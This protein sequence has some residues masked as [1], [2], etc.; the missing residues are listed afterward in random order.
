[1]AL[2]SG[3]GW[4]F[5]LRWFHFLAGITWI[6][7]LYFFNFVNVPGMKVLDPSA[8]PFVVTTILPRAL[9]WFRHAAWVT[10]LAG[11]VLMGTLYWSQGRFLGDDGAR[12]IHVGMLLGLIMLF[13]VWV[14]IWPNQKKVIAATAAKQAPEPSWARTALYASRTNVILSSPM[15]AFMAGAGHF[16]LGWAGI[17]V[18]GLV[19]AAIAALL[20]FYVHKAWLFA[21]K[22]AAPTP[23][24]T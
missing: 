18:V 9:A 24:P 13:N 15:L 12:T 2:L 23:R 17:I 5:L 19:A 22:P 20:V 16:P 11:L 14:L 1:M 7:L 21:P 4:L 8:R 10:V 3:D 6:G